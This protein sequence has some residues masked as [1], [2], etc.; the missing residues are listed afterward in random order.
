MAC[1]QN[2]GCHP[3]ERLISNRISRSSGLISKTPCALSSR[4][5][6]AQWCYTSPQTA[7]LQSA[8]SR[9]RNKT[10]DVAR[11]TLGTK[12][13]PVPRLTVRKLGI[14]SRDY[15]HKFPNGLRDFSATFSRALRALD[16]K[17]CDT[18]LFSP[19]SIIPRKT[20][21]PLRSLQGLRYVRSVLYEE[22]RDGQKSSVVRN[23]VFHRR[24]NKWRQYELPGGG[25]PK[26]RGSLKAKKRKVHRFT[27]KVLPGRN[28]ETFA[29]RYPQLRVSPRQPIR[30]KVAYHMWQLDIVH[31]LRG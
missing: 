27:R 23:V 2:S 19:W 13:E 26:L 8:G 16:E 4:A 22:F 10:K 3:R 7:M 6:V 30:S 31:I 18:V 15:N 12:T 21:D 20:F 1:A 28:S 14:V 29:K 5:H 17:R 9:Q 11:S 25:F 24:R